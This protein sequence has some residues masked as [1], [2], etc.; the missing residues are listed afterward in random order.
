M[1]AGCVGA[2]GVAAPA[3]ALDVSGSAFVRGSLTASN[4]TVT[5]TLSITG[6]FEVV[7]AY[8][9]HSSNVVIAN[10]GTGPA[11]TVTAGNGS[12]V[13]LLVDASGNVGIGTAAPRASLDVYA[14][15]AVVLPTGTTAQRPSVP[16]YGMMRLNATTSNVEFYSPVG[17]FPLQRVP[18][19]N[20]L[21][22]ATAAPSA[23]AVKAAGSSASGVYWLQ[24]AGVNAGLPFQAYCDFTI[25]GGIG[26]AIIANL[27][28]TGGVP[29]PLQSA[30]NGG[31]SGVAGFSTTHYV[32]PQTM[33]LSYGMSKIALVTR[34]NDGTSA[35]G[36]AS[37]STCRWAAI[38]SAGANFAA[39]FTSFTA[40]Q[41][42]GPYNG[43][44]GTN[45]TA[46]LPN[47]YAR[48]GGICQVGNS[49]TTVNTGVVFEYMPGE[50]GS[51]AN[52]SFSP[53][54]MAG[55]YF[56]NAALFSLGGVLNAR[57]CS[58]AVY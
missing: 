49:A 23:A 2:G 51:D 42:S 33:M 36:L 38:A 21:S 24:V 18:L 44:D 45:G 41:F 55:G 7:N 37:A 17:W 12:N 20:G 13:A 28:L 53:L 6:G 50:V 1:V 48:S 40:P 29:G 3:G 25:D 10:T 14:V 32:A 46:Y 15:D 58:I 35:G 22:A 19:K 11:L 56:N 57:W 27:F 54:L 43:S 47:G 5:G 31:I 26:Y 4:V 8:E 16:C 9:T 39:F 30:M 34:T 52:H